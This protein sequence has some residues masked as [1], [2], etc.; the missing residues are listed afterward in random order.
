MKK[1]ILSIAMLAS[2]S[3][4]AQQINYKIIEDNPDKAYSNY[5]VIDFMGV[6]M[7][8]DFQSASI[9]VGAS[10]R[11]NFTD[12]IAVEGLV[13]PTVFN[14]SGSGFGI[15]TETGV[16]YSLKTSSKNKDLPVVL[17]YDAFAGETNSGA[18]V[19]ETKYIN[20]PG[21]LLSSIGARGGLYVKSSGYESASG[22]VNIESSRFLGGVYVGMQKTSQAYIKTMIDDKMERIGGAFTRVYA[23][24]LILPARSISDSTLAATVEK[25]RAW[26]WRAGMQWYMDAHDGKYKRIG[27]SVI[28]AELGAL[29]QTG[30]YINMSWGWAIISK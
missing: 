9:Y 19:E 13:R 26:G 4:S 18:R 27:K 20:V 15:Q 30:F 3:L 17:K 14:M 2:I 29:P 12:K 6:D 24:I 1:I 10:G 23:D 7:D 25:D 11:W 8:F 22:A 21:T 28:S 5:L 16:F